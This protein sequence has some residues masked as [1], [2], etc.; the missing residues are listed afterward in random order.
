MFLGIHQ[1][2]HVAAATNC[3]SPAWYSPGS[4]SY[5]FNIQTRGK[6]NQRRFCLRSG[7]NLAGSLHQIKV[8]ILTNDEHFSQLCH[9]VS[10]IWS[11]MLTF[12]KPVLKTHLIFI[13]VVY[14]SIMHGMHF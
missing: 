7:L 3:P 4:H 14:E 13:E 5:K 11:L 6:Q 9:A 10:V 1:G 8:I 12:A 2:P